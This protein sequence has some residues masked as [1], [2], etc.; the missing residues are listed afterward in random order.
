MA[1]RRYHRVCQEIKKSG[2]TAWKRKDEAVANIVE[3]GTLK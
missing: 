1:G 3:E 2:T